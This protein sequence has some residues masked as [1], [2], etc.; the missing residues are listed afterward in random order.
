MVNSGRLSHVCIQTLARILFRVSFYLGT[1]KWQPPSPASSPRSSA[2]VIGRRLLGL[3]TQMDP[4]QTMSPNWL[5]SGSLFAPVLLYFIHTA[6][7]GCHDRARRSSANDNQR[8]RPRIFFSP[9]THYC[10]VF[11]CILFLIYLQYSIQL[12]HSLL[13]PTRKLSV[14]GVCFR[15]DTGNPPTLQ[16]VLLCVSKKGFFGE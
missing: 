4:G 13:G 16:R 1:R 3:S 6:P 11:Q 5:G 9:V 15:K 7:S 12:K 10:Y 8:R 14:R 2:R